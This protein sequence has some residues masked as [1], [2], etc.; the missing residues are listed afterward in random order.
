MSLT[1]KIE[2]KSKKPRSKNGAVFCF[3]H[4]TWLDSSIRLIR[5]KSGGCPLKHCPNMKLVMIAQHITNARHIDMVRVRCRQWSCEYCALENARQWKNHLLTRLG[6]PDFWGKMWCLITITASG[7]ANKKGPLQTLKNLQRGWSKL[8]HRLKR[9]NGAAFDYVRVFEKHTEGKYGGYH[10][11]ILADVGDS[12]IYRFTAI[13]AVL[14]REAHA[15]GLGLRP[16]KRLKKEKSPDRW[17][18]DNCAQCGMGH[19]A[20]FSFVGKTA[21]GTAR[22]ATKYIG[23][24]LEILEFPPRM[25]RI[26]GSRGMTLKKNNCSKIRQWRAKSAIYREDLTRYDKI[27]DMTARHIVSLEDDFSHGQSYYPPEMY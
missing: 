7:E 25:R 22:Y 16:R 18:K 6:R 2:Q 10:M 9:W 23:K 20:D 15:M 26:Q 13:N 19:Q 3:F 4:G 12:W 14:D 21:S 11:H 17:L 5:R 24:Q 27:Y 8:Y 1:N